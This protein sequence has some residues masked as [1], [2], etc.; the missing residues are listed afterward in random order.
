MNYD[1]EKCLRKPFHIST[2]PQH[3]LSFCE[4]ALWSTS[5]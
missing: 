2:D 1:T 3:R 5:Q 4:F